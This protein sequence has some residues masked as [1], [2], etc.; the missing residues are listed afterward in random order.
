MNCAPEALTA[1][2]VTSEAKAWSTMN[3]KGWEDIWTPRLKEK[4]VRRNLLLDGKDHYGAWCVVT[5][6]RQRPWPVHPDALHGTALSSAERWLAT[7]AGEQERVPEEAVGVD[8]PLA[9][10]L[11]YTGV[12][13]EVV[14]VPAA[15]LYLK[16]ATE[17]TFLCRFEVA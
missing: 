17:N 15:E 5:D 12:C 2:G 8:A 6:R 16:K 7:P 11:G 1:F 4:K 10:Y 14:V 9:M 3:T 13:I